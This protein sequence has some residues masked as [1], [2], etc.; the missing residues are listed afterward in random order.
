MSCK[1]REDHQKLLLKKHAK[2]ENFK[3]E[4]KTLRTAGAPR[5]DIK[6]SQV[7]VPSFH[8]YSL[9]EQYALLSYTA[10]VLVLFFDI[11]THLLYISL[12]LS[13]RT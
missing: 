10:L 6:F 4:F 11:L 8:I 7:S 1:D 9:F 5:M 13:H 12:V 3:T 2:V